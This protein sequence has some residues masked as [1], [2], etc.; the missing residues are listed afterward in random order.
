MICIIA[1]YEAAADDQMIRCVTTLCAGALQRVPEVRGRPPCAS[2]GSVRSR[3]SKY[4][5]S[6]DEANPGSR[7]LQDGQHGRGPPEVEQSAA[8]G[9]YVLV[10]AGARAEEV[11]QFIV[12]PAEPGG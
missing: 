8:I 7:G 2:A 11:A 10:V 12:S 1:I 9:G 6:W 3:A 5:L 4:R